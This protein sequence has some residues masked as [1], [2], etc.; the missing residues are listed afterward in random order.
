MRDVLLQTVVYADGTHSLL[1]TYE[2]IAYEILSNPWY[3]DKTPP[4]YHISKEILR[5]YY[6]GWICNRVSKWKDDLD[7]HI[8]FIQQV[9]K[10]TTFDLVRFFF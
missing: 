5:P 2:F 6:H 7:M 4:Y 1:T 10:Q 3:K 8:L 9:M